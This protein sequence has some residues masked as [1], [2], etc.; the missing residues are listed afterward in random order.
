[1]CKQHISR[2]N[3]SFVSFPLRG[4]Q[5]R[6]RRCFV[7]FHPPTLSF[8]SFSVWCGHGTRPPGPHAL[9]RWRQFARHTRLVCRSRRSAAAA[10][11]FPRFGTLPSPATPATP[12]SQYP[13]VSRCIL[14]SRIKGETH[15]SLDLSPFGLCS[16]SALTY[17]MIT[18]YYYLA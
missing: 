1:M 9:R 11:R 10:G 18:D 15:L 17:P 2:L 3:E 7:L 16:R 4:P 13:P 6:A 8:L 5:S 14:P 12:Q